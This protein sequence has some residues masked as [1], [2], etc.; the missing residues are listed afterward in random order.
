MKRVWDDW[1]NLNCTAPRC[2]TYV[3]SGEGN[4][5]IDEDGDLQRWCVKHW[6]GMFK[7]AKNGK[8][9]AAEGGATPSNQS[10]QEA[11]KDI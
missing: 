1:S 11:P 8:S 10:V 7:E 2:R 4:Q 5:F 9:E 6:T 3:K